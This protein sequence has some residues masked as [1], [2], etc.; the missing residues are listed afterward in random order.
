MSLL[1]CSYFQPI[2]KEYLSARQVFFIDQLTAVSATH[3]DINSKHHNSRTNGSKLITW[4]TS[5]NFFWNTLYLQLASCKLNRKAIITTRIK[6]AT[7]P[8]TAA[9]VLQ[10]I[11]AYRPIDGISRLLSEHA[12]DWQA[13]DVAPPV[14]LR[15]VSF[16]A[17]VNVIG[18]LQVACCTL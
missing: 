7:S 2:N 1:M 3:F 4:Q 12:P 15:L 16:I 11:T 10:P 6:P 18:L 5:C 9:Q 17:V 14:S 8:T 13:W